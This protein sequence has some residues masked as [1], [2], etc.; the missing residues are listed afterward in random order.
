MNP[1]KNWASEFSRLLQDGKRLP[2]GNLSPARA[3]SPAGNGKVLIFS[4]HP[5][6]ECI[7]GG[8]ALRLMRETNMRVV[9]V[10]VTQGSKKDRQ[11]GRF[12]ELQG[13]CGYLGWDLVQT[14][15]GGLERISEKTRGND[16]EHWVS[17]VEVIAGIIEREKPRV[18]LLPHAQDNNS[19]H[20]GT[21]FLVMDALLRMPGSFTSYL[22][23][24]EYWGAMADP[25]LMVE[26]GVEE[27]ADLIA[28][29]TFHVGELQRNPY[30]LSLPAWMMDNVRRGG[31]LVGG[32][33][34][35]APDFSFATLYRLR[36]WSGGQPKSFY[37]GG[38]QVPTGMNLG[39][40][41]G[42]E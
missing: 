38:R 33:G 39:E 4:P 2:L 24:T 28:A 12:R 26:I 22:V 32:Q 3:G 21:H 41:F 31:E 1:Y 23:E 27:L 5:D 25:N 37:E 16:Q 18:I 20:R 9:N 6:D 7:T 15:P 13:A 11:E 36:K 19:T 35:A 34:G 30:H 17:S 40:L 42:G 10:A 8:I 14:V 29:L